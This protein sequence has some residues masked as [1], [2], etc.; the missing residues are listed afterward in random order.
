M[1]KIS[2]K[3]LLPI[4]F[5]A[6]LLTSCEKSS[7]LDKAP[8]SF[9][10]PEN[11]YKSITDFQNAV[12]GCYDAI[13]TSTIGGT[14]VGNGTYLYGLQYMLSGGNDEMVLSSSPGTNDYTAFGDGSYIATN[15]GILS[16]WQAYF[17]GIMRCNYVIDK[18]KEVS[19]DSTDASR[20]VQI[21]G[22]AR[23]LRAFFYIHLAELFGGVPINTTSSSDGTAPRQS[24]QAVY[25]QVIIPD[26][27]YAYSVLPNRAATAGAANKWTAEGYL[28]VVYNYLSACKRYNVGNTL[29]QTL[30]SFGWVNES[31][32]T[33]SA[34]TLLQDV[35][36]NSG[37]VLI[38]NYS[39]L[40]RETTKS[41]QQQECLLTVEYATTAT[42]E[43]PQSTLI[44]SPGGS[45]YGGSYALYRNTLT[46]YSTYESTGNV[47]IRRKQNITGNYSAT[48]T[49][50][51]IDG[52]SYLVPAVAS[53][54]T[55][56]PGKYRNSAPNASRALTVQRSG[57]SIPL[58]R[59]ADIILQYAEALYFSGDDTT[60][61][62]MLLKVRTRALGT[63]SNVSTLT[64]AYYN[65]SF[66]DDLLNERRRELC[67]ESK[68]RI[69]LIR[70]GK[71]TSVIA[72]LP[73]VAAAGSN[74][75]AKLLKANWKEYKI[76][77]PIPQ[78]QRDLN[79]NLTQNDGY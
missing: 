55:Q 75:S 69:D 13:G 49:T 64:S 30:N 58:L 25:N 57:V 53:T 48:S 41:Y 59:F 44:F 10:S 8:Y 33:D 12:T 19:F 27:Q 67:F 38:P 74:A 15:T 37:Y 45:S 46:A 79:I 47:D 68:R 78:T 61:R 72:A 1:K 17:A 51:T 28:G 21:V 26:L 32:A 52:V 34:K 39:Y 4:L 35:Y 43:Y 18:S 71:L 36:Q 6:V 73:D 11:Y 77:F 60:A 29:D 7:F 50:E 9:T 24:L 42:D 54:S 23:F 40:F 31:V 2:Y 56:I 22:E 76:W 3:I 14:S 5:G 65:V 66:I 70:F 63:G 62:S 16:L 20:L